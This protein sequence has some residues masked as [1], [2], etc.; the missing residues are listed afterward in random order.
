VETPRVEIPFPGCRSPFCLLGSH[1]GIVPPETPRR[2][3]TRDALFGG[4][5]AS[6]IGDLR[7]RPAPRGQCQKPR[8][9][10]T[11]GMDF[12]AAV[13]PG[14]TIPSKNPSHVYTQDGLSGKASLHFSPQLG[15]CGGTDGFTANN[16]VL[17][18]HAGCTSWHLPRE[19]VRLFP[20]G[21]VSGVRCHPFNDRRHP[22]EAR[23]G[24]S[25]PWQRNARVSTFPEEGFV[26]VLVHETF[27]Q[28]GGLEEWGRS[29][30]WQQTP[31]VST[32]AGELL[33]NGPR[34]S[35]DWHQKPRVS[36]HASEFLPQLEH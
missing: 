35:P 15:K 10:C 21:L 17:C 18:V 28:V 2:V 6:A 19:M 1:A 27:A 34:F 4:V 20:L 12:L 31:R 7:V 30:R 33:P 13:G 26:R 32:H 14:G 24:L 23:K 9:V 25:V 11:R 22:C 8:A 29:R 5:C 16:L 3:Y 36:T